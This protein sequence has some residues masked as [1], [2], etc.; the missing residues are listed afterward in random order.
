MATT[1]SRAPASG[2]ASE[3]A[4][5]DGNDLV[6]PQ[7]TTTIADGVV[8]KIAEA[9]A[10]EVRGVH[11]LSSGLGGALR[12]LAPGVSERGSAASVEVG[13]REAIVDLELVVDYGISIPQTTTAVRQNVISRLQQMTGLTVKEVNIEVSDLFFAEE[14]RATQAERSQR[15][16]RSGESTGSK[17]E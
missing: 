4:K 15:E 17:V 5:P 9:A 7:G 8:A 11:E 13:Q 12:R 6:T 2:G 14:E 16:A 1:E 3:T 10:R